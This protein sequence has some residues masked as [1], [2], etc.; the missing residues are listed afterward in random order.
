MIVWDRLGEDAKKR[1]DLVIKIILGRNFPKPIF[2]YNARLASAST[3]LRQ[4]VQTFS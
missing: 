2:T 4:S 1:N 3:N